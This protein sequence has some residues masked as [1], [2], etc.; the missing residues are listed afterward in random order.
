MKDLQSK[1]G[2]YKGGGGGGGG[3]SHYLPSPCFSK[4]FIK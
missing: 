1:E 4:S 3:G 2:I